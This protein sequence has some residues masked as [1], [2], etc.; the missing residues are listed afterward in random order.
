MGQH[1]YE[2][3]ITPKKVV[4]NSL[5]HS[6]LL[7]GF[8]IWQFWPD[9]RNSYKTPEEMLA[10]AAVGEAVT[11]TA[12]IG[13]GCEKKS[14]EL[15]ECLW[16]SKNSDAKVIIRFPKSNSASPSFEYR[17]E[18]IV[19]VIAKEPNLVITKIESV[20]KPMS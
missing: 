20:G 7:G 13:I 14:E 19:R 9:I 4:A 16:E 18:W 11:F 8:I 10:K 15:T 17:T 5:N 12:L 2:N 3:K 6:I 1:F